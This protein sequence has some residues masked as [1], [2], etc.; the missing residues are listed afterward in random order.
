MLVAPPES[1]IATVLYCTP[2]W[3]SVAVPLTRHVLPASAAAS[4][5]VMSKVPSVPPGVAFMTVPVAVSEIAGMAGPP[6]LQ[7]KLIVY[8]TENGPFA[9]NVP[10]RCSWIV[11]VLQSGVAIAAFRTCASEGLAPSRKAQAAKNMA[12]RMGCE[13]RGRGRRY[14]KCMG[15]LLVVW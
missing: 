10:V 9:I 7:L 5:T 6:P 11:L 14:D 1:V 8:G 4:V 2:P 15:I 13:E 3:K 12:P